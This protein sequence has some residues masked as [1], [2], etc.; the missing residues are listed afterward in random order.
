MITLKQMLL[1]Q[2]LWP[3]TERETVWESAC[4]WCRPP[5]KLDRKCQFYYPS[6]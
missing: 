6:L 5:S 4:R 3:D 1:K 2:S